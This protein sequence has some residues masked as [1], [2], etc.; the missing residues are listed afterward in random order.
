MSTKPIASLAECSD[1]TAQFG[2][3]LGSALRAAGVP[4]DLGR[5]QRFVS[6]IG[7]VHPASP[8]A[9]YLCALATLTSRPEHA[10]TLQRVLGAVLGTPPGLVVQGLEV[11]PLPDGH[12]VAPDGW[13]VPGV[14]VRAS[15]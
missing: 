9:L 7:V 12:E 13:D 11:T 6:A 8:W 1:D 10:E 14:P 5:C 3:L 15:A 4:A 2:A